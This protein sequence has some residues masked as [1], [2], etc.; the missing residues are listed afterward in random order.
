MKNRWLLKALQELVWKKKFTKVTCLFWPPVNAKTFET[1]SLKKYICLCVVW[2]FFTVFSR[3]SYSLNYGMK[4]NK[5]LNN[6]FDC[7]ALC[8]MW[9]KQTN[10]QTWREEE[11]FLIVPCQ[12]DQASPYC[13]QQ[14]ESLASH[15]ILQVKWSER[16]FGTALSYSCSH[17]LVNGVIYWKNISKAEVFENS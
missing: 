5:P 4:E 17:K 16:V 10:E 1:C 11:G 13:R 9:V 14:A 3:L 8:R 6:C 7:G 15:I 12:D 2:S